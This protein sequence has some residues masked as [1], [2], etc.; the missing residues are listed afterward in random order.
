[1]C[2]FK[3]DINKCLN[4][5][6]VEWNK[7]NNSRKKVEFNKELLKKSQTGRINILNMGI[8]KQSTD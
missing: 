7:E 3:E 2:S 1:M 5:N 6:T 8:Q 4:E